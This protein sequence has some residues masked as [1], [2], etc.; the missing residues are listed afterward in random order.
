MKVILEMKNDR[1]VGVKLDRGDGDELE[2]PHIVEVAP[3]FNNDRRL[4]VTLK[5]RADVEVRPL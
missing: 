2:I 4:T 5:L 1:V 3:V